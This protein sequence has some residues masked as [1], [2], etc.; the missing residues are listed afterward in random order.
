M[1]QQQLRCQAFPALPPLP[2]VSFPIMLPEALQ[3]YSPLPPPTKHQLPGKTQFSTVEEVAMIL[4][5]VE[6]GFL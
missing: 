1:N 5:T 4:N 2:P 3:A 6:G